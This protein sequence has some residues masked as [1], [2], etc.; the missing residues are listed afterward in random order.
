MT[1]KQAYVK[2]M[3]RAGDRRSR[4]IAYDDDFIMM[5][6]P[7]TRTGRAKVFPGQGIKINYLSYWSDEMRNPK[8]EKQRVPVRYDPYN[9]AVAYAY[10]DGHWARC[11]SRNA[12]EFEGRSEKELKLATAKLAQMNRNVARSQAITATALAEFFHAAHAEE[13]IRK[14]VLKDAARKRIQASSVTS[15]ECAPDFSI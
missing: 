11:V 5:T 6:F 14:Q 4:R 1:P 12:E 13:H 10:L 3:E 9:I 7:S 8:V 15:P 2:G